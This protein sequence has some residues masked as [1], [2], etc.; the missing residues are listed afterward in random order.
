[1]TNSVAYKCKQ[2]L[3]RFHTI[4]SGQ[5]CNIFIDKPAVGYTVLQIT[6]KANIQRWSSEKIFVPMIKSHTCSKVMMQLGAI[7][8]HACKV[9]LGLLVS[10]SLSLFLRSTLICCAVCCFSPFARVPSPGPT[11]T[12]TAS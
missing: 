8:K 12:S 4:I 3:P 11:L 1:M 7:V 2:P 6:F 10:L 9:S 5:Q